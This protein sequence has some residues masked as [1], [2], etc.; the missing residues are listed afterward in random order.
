MLVSRG[1][2]IRGGAYIRDFTV[3]IIR[4]STFIDYIILPYF[5]QCTV[6]LYGGMIVGNLDS[7]YMYV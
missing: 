3:S 6:G 4:S 2:Y 7:F 5:Y 1:A